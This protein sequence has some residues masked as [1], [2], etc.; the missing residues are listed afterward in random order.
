ML[1]LWIK[2]FKL[3][4]PTLALVATTTNLVSCGTHQRSSPKYNFQDF[5]IAAQKADPIA[6]ILNAK[7]TS[8]S[9]VTSSELQVGQFQIDTEHQ[10]VSI[11]ITRTAVNEPTNPQKTTFIIYFT[12]VGVEYN[13]QNWELLWMPKPTNPF[14]WQAFKA[15]ALNVTPDQLLWTLKPWYQ[16]TKFQW[17]INGNS[18]QKSWQKNLDNEA[19][20]DTFGALT[21]KDAYQGMQGK[22]IVDEN[23]KTITAII[24]KKFFNHDGSEN[25]N[26]EGNYDADP[27][28]AV[29]TYQTNDTYWLSN[30]K[31]SA[32]EQLQSIEKITNLITNNKPAIN[33]KM[34]QNF[35]KNNWILL[36]V[37][38]AIINNEVVSHPA[39]YN[40]VQLIYNNTPGGGQI[41]KDNGIQYQNITVTNYPSGSGKTFTMKFILSKYDGSN[42]T[43]FNVILLWNANYITTSSASGV[44]AFDY[45]WN[46]NI[47][48]IRK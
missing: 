1:K 32:V 28:K 20:F 23:N 22:P 37:N 42:E 2:W 5:V 24:C 45:T 13:V 39:N 15:A 17:D 40:T 31:F 16:A 8:W 34:S 46:G 36:W 4:I 9:D 10:T 38:H 30:W 26:L 48:Q 35:E 41:G 3:S 43:N 11:D 7:V 29:I 21:S 47:V 6:I 44:K 14:S 18:N 33:E 12:A 19:V 25:K 27:I